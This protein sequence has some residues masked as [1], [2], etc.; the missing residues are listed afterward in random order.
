MTVPLVM[1]Y[2]SGEVI[3]TGVP[4]LL[5]VAEGV[6]VGGGLG[7]GVGVENGPEPSVFWAV[8][9]TSTWFGS[10]RM[11]FVPPPAIIKLV[12]CNCPE[13]FC[14]NCL[15]CSNAISCSLPSGPNPVIRSEL[16]MIF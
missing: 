15:V 8:T 4:N 13:V 14:W 5:G 9:A 1:T 11:T 3:G 12:S 10:P 2:G 16:C 6:G 7:V